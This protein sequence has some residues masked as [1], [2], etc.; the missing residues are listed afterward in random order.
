[1]KK[2][3]LAVLAAVAIIGIAGGV[4]AWE[5]IGPGR[6]CEVYHSTTFDFGGP[7]RHAYPTIEAALARFGRYPDVRGSLP[8]ESLFPT[9]E[10]SPE[11]GATVNPDHHPDSRNGGPYDIGKN[12]DVVQ[13]VTIDSHK[14]GWSIGGYGGCSPIP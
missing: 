6:V 12:G 1:M 5:N 14:H 8:P 3:V 4:W 9:D 13:S 11:F 2:A 7:G 10:D